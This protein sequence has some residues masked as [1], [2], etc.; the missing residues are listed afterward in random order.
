MVVYRIV[1]DQARTKDLSGKGAFINGGRWNNPGTFL[2]YTSINSSLALLE[3]LVHFDESEIPPHMFI[4]R[5]EVDDNAAT[6]EFPDKD[7]PVNWRQPESF[8]LKDIGD[9]LVSGNQFLAM[10]VRSAVN[11]E[12]YNVLINPLYKGFS[13]LVRVLSVEGYVLDKRLM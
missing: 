3:T 7:L 13:E 2:I 6:Y 9:K 4:M 1:K 12:E 10:K 11:P 5:M 8:E